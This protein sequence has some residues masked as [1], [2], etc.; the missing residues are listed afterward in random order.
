MFFNLFGAAQVCCY[1]RARS[2][3]T[4]FV[5]NMMSFKTKVLITCLVVIGF[6][7]VASL[8]SRA[9]QFEYT[10]FVWLSFLIYV[11][12]GFWGAF[13]RGFVYGMLLGSIAGF[14][15]STAGWFLSRMIGPFIQRKIP[16]LNPIVIVITIIVV[17]VLALALG[18]V[19]AVLC[20]LVG[21]TRTADA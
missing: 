15:D 18:S 6:D 4:L 8:L 11:V 19:G 7:V 12:I 16:P 14:T 13:R 9:F 17:T 20:K 1:R 5:V 3:Q 2:T 21:Q 10:N